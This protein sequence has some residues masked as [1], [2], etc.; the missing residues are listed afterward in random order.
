MVLGMLVEMWPSELWVFFQCILELLLQVA[1][2]L[3]ED[4]ARCAEHLFEVEVC[5]CLLGVEPTKD[6]CVIL[7]VESIPE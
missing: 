7:Q 2:S 3:Q 6:H 4:G 5:S 1:G